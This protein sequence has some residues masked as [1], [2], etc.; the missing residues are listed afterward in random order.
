MSRIRG[1]V[2]KVKKEIVDS[3]KKKNEP[4]ST[5]EKDDVESKTFLYFPEPESC[6]SA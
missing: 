5:R 2:A 4:D 1:I 3:G 6:V